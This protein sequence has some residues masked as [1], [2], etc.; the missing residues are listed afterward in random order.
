MAGYRALKVW[1]LGMSLTTRVYRL[2]GNFPQHELYGLTSQLRRAAVSIPSNIAEGHARSTA[3]EMIR[4]CSIAKGSLAELE[5]QLLVAAELGYAS[6]D[7]VAGLLESTTE[8]GR[9]LSGL[10]RSNREPNN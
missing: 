8:L 9:M 7:S 5:T 4:F 3:K 2:T 1:Q 6:Q 10:I